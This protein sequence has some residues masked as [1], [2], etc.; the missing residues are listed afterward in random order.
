MKLPF[1]PTAKEVFAHPKDF[2]EKDFHKINYWKKH[3][4]YLLVMTIIGALFLIL[5]QP[6]HALNNFTGDV[7]AKL[8]LP[9]TTINLDV[10]AA[11]LF[12]IY[13]GTVVLLM[14]ITSLKYWVT[15]WYIK[16][17]NHKAKLKET[18][19]VMTYG[20]TPGWLGMPFTALFGIFLYLAIKNGMTWS[21]LISM[22]VCLIFWIALEGYSMYLRTYAMSRIQGVKYWQAFISIYIL[23]FFTFLIVVVVLEAVLLFFIGGILTLGNWL[24]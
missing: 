10:S 15:H 1:L 24:F 2:F 13:L 4:T 11:A 23:G 9:Q 7:L 12:A 18:Y 3:L 16:A 17:W 19:A 6:E 5:K 14:F 8:G 22:L 21:Y 20:G